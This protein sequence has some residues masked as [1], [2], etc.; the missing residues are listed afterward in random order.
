MYG[1]FCIQKRIISVYRFLIGHSE[2]LGEMLLLYIRPS[3]GCETAGGVEHCVER[4][5]RL[6]R[7]RLATDLAEKRVG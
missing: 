6:E 2:V 5:E 1:I 7:L 3:I 4:W